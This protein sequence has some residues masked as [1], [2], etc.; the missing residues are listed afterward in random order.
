MQSPDSSAAQ[1]WQTRYEEKVRTPDEAVSAIQ[2]GD[3]IFIGSGAAEPQR[4]V[5]AL[6][7][8]ANAVF[9]TEIVHIMTLGIAPYAEPKWGDNFRHNAL[10][11]GP[12]VREAVAQG[13]AD[14]TPIFLGEIPRL[15]ETGRVPID[16]ALIQVSPPD[17]HGYCSYGVSTDVVKPATE[18]ANLVIAEVNRE[19]PRTLGDSFLHVDDIDFL[20]PVAYPILE[21]QVGVAD[22]IAR[23][24]GKYI[25]NLV[26]DG[27]TLQMGIGTIP[28][29]VLYYLRDKKDLGIHTEM[30]SDGMMHLV[31]LGVITNMKKTLH[32]GK[33]VAAFCMGSRALYEFV[34]NNPF[35]EFHP[36]SYTNDPFV[37]AQNDRMVSINS[38]LEV[39]L[40]GQVCAD[41]LGAYFYSGIGGQVDFVRGAARAKGGKP[42]IALPSTAA[43]GTIS[44]ITAQLK[45]GAGVVTSRGDVHY[46]VTEWGVAYLHGRTI[47]ERA[48][49]LISI[50]HPKFRPDLIR[51]AKTFKYIADDVPEISEIGMVYPERWEMTHTFEDGTRVF[52]RPI[53]MTDEEMMKDLFYRLSEQTIY[54]RFFRSLKSM[55]HR[56]LVHFVHIDYT[57]EMGIVGIVQDPDKT[58][59][60]EIICIGR[61]YLNRSTNVAEVSYLVRDDYQKRGIGSYLVKYLAR[62]ARENGIAGFEA[63][64]LPDNPPAM[65]VLHKL[66]FP[67]E[68]IASSGNYQL[69]VRFE[70]PAP[71]AK[72]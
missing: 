63:E 50:A 41:S 1:D 54:H 24:I 27:S 47:Q 52:F 22:E 21:T 12:N 17:R 6:V 40:T 48:L 7:K 2:S 57:N 46:I 67:V 20:I 15:F 62:I 72:S 29:S 71:T 61:Y 55:P 64:I 8:R 70:R 37:I 39:D 44:R 23:N 31:E 25:A 43:D 5:E 4:L 19:M 13:R 11:I 34:D 49:A 69:R 18:A 58:E 14:Y 42:I 36:V 35:I 28:D 16:V 59:R 51:Q 65:K 33:V 56:D 3:H 30:F 60:E 68:T 26:E 38:A 9:G 10:F 32:K 45:P 66:G 53:K